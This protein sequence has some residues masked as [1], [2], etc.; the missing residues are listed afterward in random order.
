[1]G[2]PYCSCKQRSLW[3]EGLAAHKAAEQMKF[4]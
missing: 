3:V 2:S 1:M 4:S